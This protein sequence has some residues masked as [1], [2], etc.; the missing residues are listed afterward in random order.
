M[1]TLLEW[2]HYDQ[3]YLAYGQDLLACPDSA[4]WAV[5]YYN[6]IYQMVQNG[7]L[8]QFDG[9]KSTAL[10]DIRHDWY[11][12]HNLLRDT[13]VTAANDS[14]RREYE[15]WYKA[16][17]QSYMQRMIENRLTVRTD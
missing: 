15:T 6:G 4:T 17:I 9:E 8:L 2:M 14:V 1:P 10:Y 3:S 12:R 13:P 5:N 11:Q 16:V 7:Y